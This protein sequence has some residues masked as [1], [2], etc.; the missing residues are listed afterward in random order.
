MMSDDT[1]GCSAIDS[2]AFRHLFLDDA[3]GENL[4][5]SFPKKFRASVN[6][7]LRLTERLL[8]THADVALAF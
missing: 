6:I 7:N 2:L 1:Y 3:R 8:K 4:W 5:F